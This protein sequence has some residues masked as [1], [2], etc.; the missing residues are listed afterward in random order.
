MGLGTRTD[1]VLAPGAKE[2][3]NTCRLDR[4][5]VAYVRVR[6]TVHRGWPQSRPGG[7]PLIME[8]GYIL[9]SA[10]DVLNLVFSAINILYTYVQIFVFQGATGHRS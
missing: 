3:V 5:L 9:R 1:T 6:M 4:M 7:S 10:R 2:L 8:Y